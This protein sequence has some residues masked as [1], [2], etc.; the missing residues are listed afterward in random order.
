MK[1]ISLATWN[2]GRFF[3]GFYR[4][5][6]VFICRFIGFNTPTYFSPYIIHVIVKKVYS[7]CFVFPTNDIMS[8]KKK[9]LE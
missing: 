6:T 9:I 4:F 2:M 3:E 7:F 1:T 8:K 5:L